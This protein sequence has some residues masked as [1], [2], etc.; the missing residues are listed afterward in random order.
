MSFLLFK[1]SFKLFVAIDFASY[2]SAAVVGR[3]V[4]ISAGARARTAV[5]L[6]LV[7]S[8]RGSV[9][10]RDVGS[11]IFVVF[12]RMVSRTFGASSF[13]ASDV[14]SGPLVLFLVLVLISVESAKEAEC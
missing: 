10:R 5:G 3:V 6:T 13:L 8:R 1:F 2:A 14:R 7:D 11:A 4:G 9:D 12:L